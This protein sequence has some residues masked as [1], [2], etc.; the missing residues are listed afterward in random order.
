MTGT[1]RRRL[2]IDEEW[3]VYHLRPPGPG[4][5]HG[6]DDMVLVPTHLAA[7]YDAAAEEWNQVQDL[8]YNF[9]VQ[10]RENR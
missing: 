1:V 2:D 7:R 5:K 6:D 9:Y 10:T 8:L 4:S 3:S